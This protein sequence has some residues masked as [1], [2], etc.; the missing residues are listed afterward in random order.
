MIF[1]ASHDFNPI[2]LVFENPK[3]SDGI[4]CQKY[5]KKIIFI[6]LRVAII[7]RSLVAGRR[8]KWPVSF[9]VYTIV[10]PEDPPNGGADYYRVGLCG[11]PKRYSIVRRLKRDAGSRALK[12]SAVTL[13]FIIL[14]SPFLL[15]AGNQPQT[16]YR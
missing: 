8:P 12:W 1:I 15:A 16:N 10:I 6:F 3:N 13:I 7:L 14:F 11:I 9:T 4:F 5:L 2:F